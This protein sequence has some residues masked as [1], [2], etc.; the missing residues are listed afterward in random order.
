M[1]LYRATIGKLE[2]ASGERWSNVYTLLDFDASSALVVASAIADME[3]A[4][5]YNTIRV[6]NVKVV[7]VA[8]PSDRLAAAYDQAGD[9]PTTGLGGPLPLFCTVRVDFRDLI[10]R[11]ERKY[12]RTGAQ[13]NNIADGRWSPEYY[14]YVEANYSEPLFGTLAYVGPNGERPTSYETFHPIQNRQ[15]GWHR[16][17]RPGMKRGWVPA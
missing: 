2:T 9:L 5:S 1:P 4:I 12:L 14:D 3:R 11:P 16:R 7:N 10:K 13:R 17:S 6:N 8:V 15:L